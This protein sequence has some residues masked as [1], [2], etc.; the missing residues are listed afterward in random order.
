MAFLEGLMAPLALLA[1]DGGHFAGLDGIAPELTL[2]L[3]SLAGLVVDL[4]KKGK[5]STLV[6][7][8]TMAGLA[9]AGLQLAMAFGEPSRTVLGLVVVDN[10]AGF[11]KLFTVACLLYTSPSPRDR[12]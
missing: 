4:V 6:G 8:I 5:D 2:V 3:F 12:G 11:F 1:E 7:W 9:V 10:F